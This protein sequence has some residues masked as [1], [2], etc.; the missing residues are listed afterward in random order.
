MPLATILGFA[1]DTLTFVGGLVLA[2]D[3]LMRDREFKKQQQLGEVVHELKGIKLATGGIKLTGPNDVERVFI[4]QSV[5]RA[6]WG[7]AVMTLGFILLLC[8]RGC[9]S[10]S[11]SPEPSVPPKVTAN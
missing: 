3:A 6:F 2:W 4:R 1:G 5:R 8:S 10:Y 7:T 11:H 9:E